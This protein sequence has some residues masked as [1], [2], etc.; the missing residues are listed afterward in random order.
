AFGVIFALIIIPNIKETIVNTSPTNTNYSQNQQRHISVRYASLT[1]PTGLTQLILSII[2]AGDGA[3][4]SE[5][6][7]ESHYSAFQ[8]SKPQNCCRSQESG[9]R[10][11]ESKASF[12]V[13]APQLAT[14]YKY[15]IMLPGN[16]DCGLSSMKTAIS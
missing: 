9:V 13:L 5:L 11:Q 8:L 12:K 2:G 6:N 15:F 7:V 1:H 10:S 16:Y 3:G 14:E 4:S